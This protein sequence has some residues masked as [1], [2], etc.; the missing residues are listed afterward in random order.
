MNT[1]TSTTQTASASKF[2]QQLCKHFAHK[3][4]AERDANPGEVSFPF[5]KRHMEAS[6]TCRMIHCKAGDAPKMRRARTVLDDRL[7][8]YARRRELKLQWRSDDTG[9]VGWPVLRINQGEHT[10]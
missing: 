8:L 5:G 10:C 2:L 7:E 4:P 1:A 3:V 6:G 9:R